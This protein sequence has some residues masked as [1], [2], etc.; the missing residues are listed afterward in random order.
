MEKLKRF[1]SFSFSLL[2]IFISLTAAIGKHT[3]AIR[4]H[5]IWWLQLQ[6]LASVILLCIPNGIYHSVG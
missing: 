1:W 4:F 5:T 6:K 3:T 2:L